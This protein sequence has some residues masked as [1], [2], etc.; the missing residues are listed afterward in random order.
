MNEWQDIV[1]RH[2]DVFHETLLLMQGHVGIKLKMKSRCRVVLANRLALKDVV[3][4]QAFYPANFINDYGYAR[5]IK[6]AFCVSS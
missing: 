4:G 6:P 3:G 2:M 5:A 1:Q